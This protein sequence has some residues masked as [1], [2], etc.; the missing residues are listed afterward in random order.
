MDGVARRAG[1]EASRARARRDAALA[2]AGWAGGA[3]GLAVAT[4]PLLGLV[5]AAGAGVAVVGDAV[6]SLGITAGLVALASVVA[7]P[8]GLGWGAWMDA[9]RRRGRFA[10][11][12]AITDA[13]DGGPT[14][15]GGLFV[16][17]WLDG[18]LA[19]ELAG[20]TALAIPMVPAVARVA[21]RAF[22][23]VGE[24]PRHTAMALGATRWDVWARV[25]VPA[26]QARVSAGLAR[27]VAR[28]FGQT[29]PLVV[30][31]SPWA[32]APLSVRAFDAIRAGHGAEAAV[33]GVVLVGVSLGLVWAANLAMRAA[34]RADG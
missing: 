8:V 9:A 10:F 14:L 4:L 26:T 19:T 27:V 24:A 15:A 18:H 28:A 20:A 22:E 33:H 3:V 17:L 23:D 21:R 11:V 30:L 16:A 13:L 29:T 25:I 32:V 31:S 12:A 7:I 5:A 2:A 34:G 1:D 6:R